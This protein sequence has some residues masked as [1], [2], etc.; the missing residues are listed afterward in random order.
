MEDPES[1][2]LTQEKKQIPRHT[3][4]GAAGKTAALGTCNTV[5]LE[6][7]GETYKK[8]ITFEFP[9]RAF[10]RPLSHCIL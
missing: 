4:R 8:H 6:K 7:V 3:G 10:S 5:A 2:R 9:S 1:Q